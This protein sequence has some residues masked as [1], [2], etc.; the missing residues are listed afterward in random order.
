MPTNAVDAS[1]E[2][3][4]AKSALNDR[5]G[6]GEHARLKDR[7]LEWDNKIHRTSVRESVKEAMDEH[8]RRCLTHTGSKRT[9]VAP[10]CSVTR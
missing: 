5:L 4:H 3:F 6:E 2:D 9:L 1:Y 8:R 7:S 10:G